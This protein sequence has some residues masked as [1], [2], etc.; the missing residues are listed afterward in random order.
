[1]QKLTQSKST[2]KEVTVL[3]RVVFKNDS[4]KVVYNV[5]SSNGKDQYQ[6]YFFDGKVCS[7]S[8]PATKPCYHMVQLQAREDAREE[9]VNRAVDQALVARAETA[10]I[11]YRAS[12]GHY[13]STY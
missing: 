6:V 11:T 12:F 5:L 10:A 4:R 1:M 2:T 3:A 7:C 9:K 8:C 13:E